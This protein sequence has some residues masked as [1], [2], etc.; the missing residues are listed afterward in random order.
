MRGMGYNFFKGYIWRAIA[1]S[2]EIMSVFFWRCSVTD[3]N[4]WFGK[5]VVD[6]RFGSPVLVRSMDWND[7]TSIKIF[8][9]LKWMALN[10]SFFFQISRMIF[11]PKVVYLKNSSKRC[12]NLNSPLIFLP[13]NFT[14]KKIT[15]FSNS[16]V[17]SYMSLLI[18]QCS[19]SLM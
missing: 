8:L 7:D 12:K 6:G 9:A 4:E 14:S 3:N 11:R 17:I 2:R 10:K 19:V 13:L 15:F 18:L 16:L 5:Y 1:W